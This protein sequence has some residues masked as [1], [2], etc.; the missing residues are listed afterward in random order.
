MKERAPTRI[1]A[2]LADITHGRALY[3]VPHGKALDRLVFGDA[4]RAVRAADETDV[5]AV[6]L[7][8]TAISS[9]LGLSN[10]G[11]VS[12]SKRVGRYAWG[13][14]CRPSHACVLPSITSRRP[15]LALDG[16]TTETG[17]FHSSGTGLTML[18]SPDGVLSV[19][20]R[21]LSLDD[22]SASPSASSGSVPTLFSITCPE[23]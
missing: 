11:V 1:H 18:Q 3:H 23:L 10:N 7:V 8:T 9:F 5:A 6:F 19:V 20:G 13:T 4:P 15:F 14:P 16:S 17:P 22:P 2:R 12:E 21:R